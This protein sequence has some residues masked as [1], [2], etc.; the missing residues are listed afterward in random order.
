MSAFTDKLRECGEIYT[1]RTADLFD[2]AADRI[3]ALELYREAAKKRIAELEN[4]QTYTA[5][6]KVLH[7]PKNSKKAKTSRGLDLTQKG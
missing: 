1:G 2:C 5:A 7:D 6:Q 4:A 3:E